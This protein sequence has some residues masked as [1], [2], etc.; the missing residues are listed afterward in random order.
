[1]AGRGKYSNY[2]PLNVQSAAA[3]ARR[4]A[5]FNAKAADDKGA[6]FGPDGGNISKYV[7]MSGMLFEAGIGD[8]Q[9]FPTGIDFKF[10][11][12]PNLEDTSLKRAGDPGNPYMPDVSS[13]G[14]I[15]G[16]INVDPKAKTGNGKIHIEDVKPNY[17]PASGIVGQDAQNM[18]TQSPS[19][20]ST[21]LGH[22]TLLRDMVLGKSN[23]TLGD[24]G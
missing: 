3:Y 16:A 17:V 1:M 23:G 11:N 6:F 24:G 21:M 8:V 20:T 7:K 19:T 18:G 2:T 12:A 5:L 15:D 22:S 4:Y 9:M 13:P 14:A 10:G